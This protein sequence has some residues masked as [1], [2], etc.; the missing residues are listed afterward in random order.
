MPETTVMEPTAPVQPPAT[1]PTPPALAEP[2]IPKSRF[3]EINNQKKEAEQQ[4]QKYLDA[5][6]KRKESEMT[7]LQKAQ[8]DKEAAEK[9]V[10]DAEEK[11]NK[12]TAE[13]QEKLLK[14]AVLL[15]AGSMNF[16]H[17]D[18]AYELAK[19]KNVL[20]T[21]TANETGDYDEKA[22]EAALKPLVGRLPIKQQGSGI[23]SAILRPGAL[24]Q[25]PEKPK[26]APAMTR[27]Y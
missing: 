5:E 22:I 12:A 8:A 15:K 16:E 4:L 17:P 7:D 23:G 13:A 14:S 19:S 10:A 1:E 6:Q 27:R 25:T 26:P 9:K 20:S 24:K 2:M 3:D 21:L 18:D 11:A